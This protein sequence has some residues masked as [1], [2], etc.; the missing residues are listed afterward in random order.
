MLLLGI[1]AGTQSLK[2]VAV[3]AASLEVRGR[4][5]WPLAVRHP[6]PGAAEQSPADWLGALRPAIGEALRAAAAGPA[7]VAAVGVTGQ[8][9]GCVVVDREG[10]PLGEALIW[11]DRRATAAVDR[12]DPGLLRARAGL[13][14]DASHQAA[15]IRWL[16]D[17]SDLPA[18]T[19]FHQPVS[20][21]VEQLTG[22]FVQDRAL[23]ST[24]MLYG[25]AA[26]DWDEE[27][28]RAFAIDPRL[29]PA[30]ADASAKAGE[31][32]A[33]GA[34]LSGLRPGTPVAVGTGDDFANAIGAGV[35]RPGVV[36]CCV[37]TAEVVG[38]VH[39]QAVL[40]AGAL[41]ET[42]GFPGGR[43][44]VENPGWLSGGAMRWVR[45][46]LG[47]D[48]WS[49]LEALADAA[50]PGADGVV[51]LP[52]LTGAMAPEWLAHARGAVYGLAPA[53]GPG[54][55]VRAVQEGAAFAMADVIDRLA[56]LGVATG[57]IRLAGGGARSAP[58]ARMRA[59]VADKPVE[60]VDVEDVAAQGAVACAAVVSGAAGSLA[61][62]AGRLARVRRTVLPD[63]AEVA[64]YRPARE[65]ARTL[66]AALRPVMGKP[67]I[68]A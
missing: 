41:V 62:A 9:D 51:A 56:E 60:I 18:G 38:A 39:D 28:C 12:V 27:L 47:L 24:S 20:F 34:E 10:R 44:F 19:R 58:W 40:D 59:A 31:V 61:E 4:G 23:A 32:S 11:M 37:G 26:Q 33:S 13:V 55:L 21:L 43:F 2:A 35:T 25:L 3:D 14:A 15:K 29:L 68:A 45:D 16:M 48:G 49:A 8:L 5:S 65:R 52:T 1:D 42:H 64:A 17:H 54:H 46:L 67:W 22:A 53:H 6:F 36:L 7:D 30:L 50:P 66:F 57:R 63:P